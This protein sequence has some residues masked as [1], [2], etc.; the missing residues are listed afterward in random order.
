MEP[1]EIK[2]SESQFK[3]YNPERLTE[4]SKQQLLEKFKADRQAAE[5]AYNSICE[6]I[7]TLNRLNGFWPILFYQEQRPGDVLIE[8]NEATKKYEPE[9]QPGRNLAEALF[10]VNTELAEGY[11][12]WRKGGDIFD[13]KEGLLVELADAMIRLMD[14]GF[15]LGGEKFTKMMLDKM[16]YNASRPFRHGNKKS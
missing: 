8:A 12:H 13:P 7:H 9:A 14:M 15:A 10:L 4:E 3:E 6:F 16:E 2:L 5:N 1:N 11:E